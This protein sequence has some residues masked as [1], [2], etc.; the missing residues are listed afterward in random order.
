MPTKGDQ[1]AVDL[2]HDFDT[3]KER[4]D[5]GGARD[6]DETGGQQAEDRRETKQGP[7]YDGRPQPGDEDAHGQ[8]PPDQYRRRSVV[9]WIEGQATF[10]E[11]KGNGDGDDRL[12]ALPQFPGADDAGQQEDDGRNVEATC[13][14]DDE[15]AR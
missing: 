13:C 8:Q 6:D 2:R 4:T 5:D 3:P 1:D 11:D 7:E 10:E 15:D 9:L 14:G 12:Q